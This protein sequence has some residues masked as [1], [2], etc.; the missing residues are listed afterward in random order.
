MSGKR[1]LQLVV[2]T[3]I[4][5]ASLGNT[6]SASAWE[7]A[8]QLIMC[9]GETHSAALRNCAASPCM[10][11]NVPTPASDIGPT[12]VRRLLFQEFHTTPRN[13]IHPRAESM[14]FNGMR[15]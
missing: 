1:I 13:T 8:A 14:L 7:D 2:L 5:L 11:Y 15:L 10:I 6:V 9:N 12:L 3:T 4:M